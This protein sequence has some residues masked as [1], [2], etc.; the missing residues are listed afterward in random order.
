MAV[1]MGG[2]IYYMPLF[3]DGMYSDISNWPQ[4]RIPYKNTPYSMILVSSSFAAYDTLVISHSILK[5]PHFHIRYSFSYSISDMQRQAVN[6]KVHIKVISRTG[7]SSFIDDEF[8]LQYPS[9]SDFVAGIRTDRKV[10][11][12]DIDGFKDYDSYTECGEEVQGDPIYPDSETIR[13]TYDGVD[14]YYDLVLKNTQE[15]I[16]S[17]HI[18]IP[19]RQGGTWQ[20]E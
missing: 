19:V 8:S 6:T 20:E 15:G 2:T 3:Y 7:D 16:F 5:S 17:N 4:V 13:V 1:K 18:K 10:F 12:S 11:D 14:G 9:S